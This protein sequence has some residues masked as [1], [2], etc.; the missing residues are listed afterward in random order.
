MF[1]FGGSTV[2]L[3][4][5]PNRAHLLPEFVADGEER[6]VRYGQQIGFAVQ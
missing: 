1:L 2:V 5:E 6:K 4:L 3:L